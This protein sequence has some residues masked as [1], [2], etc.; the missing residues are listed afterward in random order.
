MSDGRLNSHTLLESLYFKASPLTGSDSSSAWSTSG[1]CPRIFTSAFLLA[2][3][4]IF[5]YL[6]WKTH[7]RWPCCMTPLNWNCSHMISTS[8]HCH[9]RSPVALHHMLRLGKLWKWNK[10]A[11]VEV[12]SRRL[13]VSVKV[14]NIFELQRHQCEGVWKKQNIRQP[15]RCRT[16]SSGMETNKT[17]LI[18]SA[19]I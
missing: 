18:I 10:L 6:L 19:T 14:F 16:D 9:H 3:T 2:Q 15:R 17:L 1:F 8:Q 7:M 4:W 13:S 12:M 11:R 5:V